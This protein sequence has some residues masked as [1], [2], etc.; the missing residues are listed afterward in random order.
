MSDYQKAFWLGVAFYVSI[1]IA[2]G[3]GIG[4]SVCKAL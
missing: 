1:G 2:I 4:F 3:F